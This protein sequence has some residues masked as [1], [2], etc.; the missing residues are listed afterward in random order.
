MKYYLLVCSGRHGVKGLAFYLHTQQLKR[1]LFSQHDS[2]KT[3]TYQLRTFELYFI[4]F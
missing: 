4:M 3:S 2:A 1:D